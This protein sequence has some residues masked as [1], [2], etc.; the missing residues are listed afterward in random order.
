MDYPDNPLDGVVSVS[1][2][3]DIS[4]S[5]HKCLWFYT[6]MLTGENYKN[7]YEWICDKSSDSGITDLDKFFKKCD[8]KNQLHLVKTPLLFIQSK[9]DDIINGDASDLIKFQIQA[10]TH[11]ALME[12]KHGGHCG[13]YTKTGR[14]HLENT[15][16]FFNYLTKNFN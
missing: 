3:G 14:W 5:G 4:Y 1:G 6:R 11:I 8:P 15:V 12:T 9:D 10:N 2:A 16:K 13:F 7:F